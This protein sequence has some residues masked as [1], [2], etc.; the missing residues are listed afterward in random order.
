M[1]LVNAWHSN[2]YS[3]HAN[4]ASHILG[5]LLGSFSWPQS[6]SFGYLLLT[7]RGMVNTKIGP[8]HLSYQVACMPCWLKLCL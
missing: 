4:N 8:S 1:S 6:T 2:Y 7:V 3:L 5:E